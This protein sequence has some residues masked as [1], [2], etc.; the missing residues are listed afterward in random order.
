MSK[1]GEYFSSIKPRLGHY[2]N[3]NYKIKQFVFSSTNNSGYAISTTDVEGT[4]YKQHTNS[5]YDT[6]PVW[7]PDNSII[8]FNRKTDSNQPAQLYFVNTVTG[9]DGNSS[10]QIKL[11]AQIKLWMAFIRLLIYMYCPNINQNQI[12][13]I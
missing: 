10:I 3:W 1:A 5:Y 4:Y 7:G 2:V 12:E 11:M 8:L 6:R 9:D 13:V